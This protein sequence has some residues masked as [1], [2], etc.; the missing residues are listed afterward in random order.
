MLE[1]YSISVAGSS[2][3][4]NWK[5]KTYT[6]DTRRGVIEAQDDRKRDYERI[7][8]AGEVRESDP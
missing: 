5:R 8:Q 7:R 4:T 1:K 2:K 6:W 3:S